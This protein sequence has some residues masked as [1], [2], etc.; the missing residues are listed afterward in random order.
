M[1]LK[2]VLGLVH[3]LDRARP[4][5][6]RSHDPM[7]IY[8]QVLDINRY[9]KMDLHVLDGFKALVAG[10]PTPTSGNKPRVAS[11]KVVLASRDPVAL[12]IVG[13]ALL[14]TLSPTTER[15]MDSTPWANPM[16]SSARAAALGRV[17]EAGVTL[18]GSTFAGLETLSSLIS[19][20]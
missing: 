17:W 5:N 10:G 15:V 6:L 7:R 9:V 18:K 14:Q 3:P 8:K 20:E 13:V 4:G 16:I 1:A 11:P 12:D 19:R 2:N